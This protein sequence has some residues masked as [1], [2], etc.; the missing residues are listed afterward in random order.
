[1]CELGHV[2]LAGQRVALAVPSRCAADRG[3]ALL[4]MSAG[5]CRSRSDA[6]PAGW[7]ALSGELDVFTASRIGDSLDNFCGLAGD[8]VIDASAVTFID[9]AG[10]ALLQRVLGRATCAGRA[11]WL[12]EP[13]GVVRR[14]TELPDVGDRVPV[15]N[16]RDD[17]DVDP[18][19]LP[20]WSIGTTG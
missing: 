2:P 19:T 9:I 14:L 5:A 11:A 18:I 13:S 15:C 3:R 20:A 17:N 16:F 12:H 10:L 8:V 7:V 1:M 6:R 4:E